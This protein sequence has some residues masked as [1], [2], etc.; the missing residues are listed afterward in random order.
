VTALP[1]GIRKLPLARLAPSPFNVRSVRT[2][3]RV[4][5]IARS[6]EAD[7]QQEPI[8]VYPGT[9]AEAQSYLIVSG[10][11][12]YFAALRLDWKTLDAR[13][14]AT[15]DP[16]N[17]LSLVKV[18]RLH[19]DTHRETE[20]DHAILARA[21]KEAGYMT[22]EIVK[23]L[24]YGSRRS[25]TRLKAYFELPASILE[26]GTTR[27]EKFS[28]SFAELLKNAAGIIGEEK[29]R[30]LL[31]RCFKENL[32]LREVERLVHAEK[33]MLQRDARLR[34]WKTQAV[35]LRLEGGKVGR[36]SVWETPEKKQKIQF[37]ALVDKAMGE[38][39]SA[40]L[41][42]FLNRFTEETGETEKAET[43]DAG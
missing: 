5:E 13:V 16:E 14:D 19:N 32:S 15:L 29:T 23:A 36:L 31:E 8:T 10:V 6:L 28:T 1:T 2:D 18:S 7:G 9:G 22:E 37:S 20:L 42:E 12:R 39:L 33:R 24:G 41:A 21:L 40:Q 25:V 26:L 35:D 27:P 4:A 17:A 3:A 34:P 43:K 38:R 30:T 11:T